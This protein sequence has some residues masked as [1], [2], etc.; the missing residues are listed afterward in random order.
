[1][2]IGYDVVRPGDAEW[3]SLDILGRHSPFHTPDYLSLAMLVEGSGAVPMVM[4]VCLEDTVLQLPLIEKPLPH[5]SGLNEFSDVSSP[6]GFASPVFDPGPPSQERMM[7]MARLLL[8][9]GHELHL[10]SAFL[11]LNP[12][13]K[14]QA[15]AWVGVGNVV[16]EGPVV[17]VDLQQTEEEIWRTTRST[18]KSEIRRLK[19]EGY[20][21]VVDREDLFPQFV[22]AYRETMDRVN[23]SPFYYFSNEFLDATARLPGFHLLSVVS[24][25]GAVAAA[26]M[27]SLS[28]SDSH[29]FLGGTRDD[30]TALSPAK[31][32]LHEARLWAKSSGATWLNLG[33]GLGGAEDGLY[34][35]KAGFSQGRGVYETVRIIFNE[36]TYWRLLRK[37]P[38]TTDH[39]SSFFPAYRG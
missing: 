34:R 8:E 13:D 1:M 28:G 35:F 10:V 20:R 39:V 16:R 6:Y 19:R 18:V 27:F 11:R 17:I 14:G 15:T 32:L 29:Y 26:G 7:T 9:V 4:R 3:S 37:T 2:A 23:A 38:N 21:L 12:L 24:P 22:L 30:Y 31:L 25:R 33:G 36:N 5:G